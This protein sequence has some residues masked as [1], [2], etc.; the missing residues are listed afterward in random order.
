[1][2]DPLNVTIVCCSFNREAALRATL[3][4]KM[5]IRGVS[6]ILVILDGS[7]DGSQ[8]FI[9]G[10]MKRDARLSIMNLPH[11]GVQAARNAGIAAAEGNWLLMIDDDDFCPP[12]YLE[13]LQSTAGKFDAKVVGAAWFNATEVPVEELVEDAKSRPSNRLSFRSHPS[14]VTI[15]DVQSP[16]LFSVVLIQRD[17]ARDYKYDSGYRGNSWR[18]ETDL[19]VRIAAD[20][21]PIARSAGTFSWMEHRYGGGHERS[22]RLRY[23]RWVLVNEVRFLRRNQGILRQLEESWLGWPLEVVRTILPRWS[24]FLRASLRNRIGLV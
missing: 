2:P 5:Q 16:F 11:G 7:T 20:G 22:S 4:N 3:K 1:M 8:A 12:N 14:T 24:R 6:Q 15:D 13:E 9:E 10:E 19:F 17:V 21:I 18:E 23:E